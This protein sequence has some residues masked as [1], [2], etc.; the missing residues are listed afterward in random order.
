MNYYELLVVVLYYFQTNGWFHR[1]ANS[2]WETL[3]E[4]LVDSVS[5]AF[6]VS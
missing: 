5:L 4:L 3:T 2:L 1:A 6:S